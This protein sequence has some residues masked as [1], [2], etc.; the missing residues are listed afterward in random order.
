[1]GQN[2][3]EEQ[4]NVI[5]DDS[6]NIKEIEVDDSWRKDLYAEEGYAEYRRN[7]ELAKNYHVFDVPPFLEVETS[8]A[9][10]YKCPFCPQVTLPEVPI[11]GLMKQPLIDKLFDE[12]ARFKVPSVSLSHGGEPLIRKDI[13][14]LMRRL[15]EGKVFD[16]M[17][18]TNAFL[19][20]KELSEALILS[21][22]TKINF[23]LDAITPEIYDQ[24]RIGGNYDRVIGNIMNF[25]EVKKRLGKSYPRTRV[26]FVVTE[27][28]KHQQ[29]A[30]YE[31]WKDKVNVIA[32][33][34]EYDFSGKNQQAMVSKLKAAVD[35][36]L[37][38]CNL[39]WEHMMITHEGDITC[40]HDYN[41]DSALGN[42]KT[43]TIHECWNSP[44]MKMYRQLHQSN[45][46]CEIDMCKK[47]VTR[48][49][50]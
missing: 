1:M 22:L 6:Y 18:H 46:W 48:I 10:N 41:H 21:G 49:D 38:P 39:L 36:K 9:C 23:S 24:I 45:R 31:F 2:N 19:L 3:L 28:N 20:R 25:L 50:K 17:I 33:Q 44:K 26:S 32:F 7:W 13:P 5:V 40:N 27:T 16:R 37:K 34:Q 30:F 12:I 14:Q 11:G 35:M 43:H 47:C 29:K 15:K 4:E 8:Y 42:L